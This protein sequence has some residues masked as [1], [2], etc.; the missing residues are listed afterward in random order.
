[1]AIDTLPPPA[2]E[3]LAPVDDATRFDEITQ[4]QEAAARTIQRE[5]RRQLGGARLGDLF[6]IAGAFTASLGSTWAVTTQ[7][8]PV[9]G[10][11]GPL[12]IAYVLFLVFYALLLSF[13][14]P[15]P[16]VRDRVAAVI[17][18]SLAIIVVLTLVF[19]V[20]FTIYRGL[21]ALRFPNFFVQDMSLAGPLDPLSL[22]GIIHAI[23][24]SLIQ[25]TIAL[26]ITIPLGILTA[27]YLNEMPG[28]F[29]S[30]VRT[31]VEAMSALPS[32]V[33]GLFIYATAILILGLEK[34][35]FAAALAISVMM[36]PIMIRA[37]D[38]VIRMV[39]ATL[40]E[41]AIGLGAGQWRTVW[42]V[43]LPTSRSG[44]TTAI[45]LATARGIGETSPVL[46]TSGFTAALNLDAFRGP[47]ISLPLAVF[48]FVKSPEPTMIARGF[49]A[50]AVLMLLVLVLFAGAR[51]LGGRT[52]EKRERARVRRERVFAS[53][54]AALAPLG[55]ALAPLG[56]LAVPVLR[57]VRDAI[58]RAQVWIGRSARA[59]VA[60]VGSAI[61]E[62]R[63]QKAARRGDVE[64]DTP[65]TEP[66]PSSHH[67]AGETT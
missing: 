44:L 45:I 46:L 10:V 57:S 28:R 56:R 18:H 32:I 39:P 54:A 13:N 52:I 4:G 42:H 60:R 48:Q 40:K 23:V 35:G 12:L 26:V 2:V 66:S 47:M 55:R 16:V 67:A 65:T 61:A 36:L 30:F 14:E 37:A 59:Y 27:L 17:V 19:V 1:M 29:A 9:T 11:L 8:M 24:G 33:A 41:G 62:R 63:A 49:G 31:V 5:V 43:V 6:A 21:E 53:I 34:S 51:W 50:A 15:G 38:V 64:V 58:A 25:I 22:G 20:T 3:Q 7:I